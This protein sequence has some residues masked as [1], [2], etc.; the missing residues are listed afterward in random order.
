MRLNLSI[1][2]ALYILLLLAS[3]GFIIL[4]S[5]SFYA[6][7][8]QGQVTLNVESLSNSGIVLLK[9]EIQLLILQRDMKSI[10]QTSSKKFLKQ[11]DQFAIEFNH[12]FSNLNQTLLTKNAKAIEQLKSDTV[13]YLSTLKQLVEVKLKMGMDSKS[14][15]ISELNRAAIKYEGEIRILNSLVNQFKS[16]R[17]IE[18]DFLIRGTQALSEQWK[19]SLSESKEQVV[20][21]GFDSQLLPFLKPYQDAANELITL[22]LNYSKLSKQR[23]ELESKLMINLSNLSHQASDSMLTAAKIE[24]DN[25]R[26]Q[27]KIILITATI[28]VFVVM[29]LF[30]ITLARMMNHHAHSILRR[31]KRVASGDLTERLPVRAENNEFSQIAVGINEMIDSLS[32]LISSLK[33]SGRVLAE[34]G[35]QLSGAIDSL[36][37]SGEE[38]RIKT[39]RLNETTQLI[40]QSSNDAIETARVLEEAAQNS[41]KTADDGAEIITQAIQALSTI[42]EIIAQVSTGADEL[43][44]YSEEIDHVIELISDVAEQTNLLALNAAIEAAR[45]GEHGRGFAVVADEVR[46][47]AEQTISASEKITQNIIAIQKNTQEV[48][49]G[50]NLAQENASASQGLGDQALASIKTISENTKENVDRISGVRSVLMNITENTQSM[51]EESSQM[52]DLASNNQHEI[53]CL[54]KANEVLISQREQTSHEINH[55]SI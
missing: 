29:A 20:M 45:A 25:N 34:S 4:T 40:S 2:H 47:L 49:Q 52:T 13:L 19:K 36:N 18:H 27:V 17:A 10:N 6:L 3:L 7:S 55:F 42:G 24:A 8:K 37:N 31:L 21:I 46:S 51:L 12:I 35:N 33:T 50:V 30:V 48:I 39:G 14:G 26:S 38:I 23:Y 28:I 22:K 44:Q 11:L 16:V 9:R 32:N 53:S 15:K 41:K 54:N 5:A 1:K 43:G